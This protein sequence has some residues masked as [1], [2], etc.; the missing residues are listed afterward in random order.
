[1]FTGIIEE[2]ATVVSVEAQQQN[3][4]YWLTCSFTEKLQIDQS[5]AHNGACLTVVDI[6][7]DRY[8]VDVIAETLQ[9]TNVADWK[10]GTAVNLERSVT[11]QQRLDGHI[12][13]GH[14]DTTLECT[15]RTDEQ[16]SWRFTF[17]Y[18]PQD[19]NLFIQKGSVCINGVSLTIASLT[20]QEFSVAIIPYTF[21]HTN[22]SNITPGTRVNIE[23]DMIGKYVNRLMSAR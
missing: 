12:V 23:F 14:V 3:M 18:L 5:I 11:L 8:A 4:R 22:F 9:K 20:E 17:S 6:K 1:M 15:N 10:I 2:I 19:R 16:G 7:E 21:A 13:Q